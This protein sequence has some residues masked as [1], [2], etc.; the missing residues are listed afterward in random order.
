MVS[1][2][3][4]RLLTGTTLARML[5]VVKTVTKVTARV[6]SVVIT[7]MKVYTITQVDQLQI[8][9]TTMIVVIV[10]KGKSHDED[11]VQLIVISHLDGFLFE[12]WW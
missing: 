3:Y 12:F 8:V 7:T 6:T 4:L 1:I 10:I 5:V 9:I 2:Y 11:V